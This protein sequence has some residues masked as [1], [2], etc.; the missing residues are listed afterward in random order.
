VSG[1]KTDIQKVFILSVSSAEKF[2]LSGTVDQEGV[3]ENFFQFVFVNQPTNAP[4]SDNIMGNYG[5]S[6]TERRKERKKQTNKQAREKVI[7]Q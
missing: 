3:I 2:R 5:G 1:D 7:F 6:K 4:W